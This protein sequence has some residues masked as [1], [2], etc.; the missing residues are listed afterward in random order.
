[1]VTLHREH[2][3]LALQALPHWQQEAVRAF[4]KGAG[5][6]AAVVALPPRV[7]VFFGGVEG[8]GGETSPL[9]IFPAAAAASAGSVAGSRERREGIEENGGWG[10]KGDE[11]HWMGY[12][13]QLISEGLR[14][15]CTPFLPATATPIT[16]AGDVLS[17]PPLP[18]GISE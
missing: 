17:F 14:D 6:T 18:F 4:T 1:M 15:I 10:R 11:E 13:C 2:L 7:F 12:G 16:P 8:S 9:R 3:F 5:R